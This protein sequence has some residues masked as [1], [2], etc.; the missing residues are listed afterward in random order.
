MTDTRLELS[1]EELRR[2]VDRQQIVDVV[3]RWVR[4]VDRRDWAAIPDLFHPEGQ[5]NHGAYQ[6]GVAGLIDW[7]TDRHTQITQSM[8]HLGSS[9]VEFKTPEKAHSETYIVAYQR[10]SPEH[11]EARTAMLGHEWSELEVPVDITSGGRYLDTFEKRE[12]EWRILNRV[13]VFEFIRAEAVNSPVLLGE[14]WAIA[15]RSRE[16]A[17]Y[18]FDD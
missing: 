16:D 18:H 13:T 11:R 9:L 5:D 3:A 15:A 4:A 10:Y 12:G 8:H 1:N 7:L 6:G 17:V 2:M 14:D